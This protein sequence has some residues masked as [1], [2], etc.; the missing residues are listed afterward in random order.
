[1]DSAQGE[2]LHMLFT[3]TGSVTV[4]KASLPALTAGFATS[5]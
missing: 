4:S 3:L 1:M 2:V 5:D